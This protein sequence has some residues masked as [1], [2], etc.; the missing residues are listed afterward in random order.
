LSELVLLSPYRP[1]QAVTRDGVVMDW[2]E[3]V[4]D[5]QTEVVRASDI[6]AVEFERGYGDEGEA[7]FEVKVSFQSGRGAQKLVLSASQAEAFRGALV[8]GETLRL[9]NTDGPGSGRLDDEQ[10]EWVYAS[11]RDLP[12][13]VE[14]P[15]RRKFPSA[16]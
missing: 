15:T 9:T 1:D 6:V 14:P 16:G 2:I 5:R 11:R 13:G 10:N 3:L 4:N 8:K 7:D 12:A